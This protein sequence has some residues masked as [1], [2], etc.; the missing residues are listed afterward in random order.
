MIYKVSNIL[1]NYII[2]NIIEKIIAFICG[3]HPRPINDTRNR[4]NLLRGRFRW[5]SSFQYVNILQSYK[6]RNVFGSQVVNL[7]R[8]VVRRQ[9]Q[10]TN[11]SGNISDWRTFTHI[12]HFTVT[13]RRLDYGNSFCFNARFKRY[14]LVVV[15]CQDITK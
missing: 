3:E 4:R 13:T 5:C 12:G 1:I 2:S 11:A 10:L 15:F 8:T 6:L 7:S 14:I 9:L